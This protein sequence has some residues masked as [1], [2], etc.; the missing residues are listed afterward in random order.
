M[1]KF[2]SRMVGL[3]ALGLMAPAVA[4]ASP[5]CQACGAYCDILNPHDDEAFLMCFAGC[6]NENGVA[7]QIEP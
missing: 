4:L 7:C 1:L 6:F 2:K 3:L 5:L